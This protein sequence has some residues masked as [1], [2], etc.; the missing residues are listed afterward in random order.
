[1]NLCLLRTLASLVST[2]SI[3]FALLLWPVGASARELMLLVPPNQDQAT[4]E[5]IEV[6]T[7]ASQIREAG[8]T[9]RLVRSDEIALPGRAAELV[10]RGIVPLALIRAAQIP[11]YQTDTKDLMFTSLLSHPLIVKD[12]RQQFFV[13]DSV[14]GDVVKQELGRK[15]FVVLGF[16]NTPSSS[17][18]F[19]KPVRSYADLKGLK[20]RAPDMQSHEV[21]QAF[22]ASPTMLA[23]GEIYAAL[24]RGTVDG[25]EAR[26]ERGSP[27]L[28]AV[29]GGSLV[30]SFMHGQ[31]FLVAHEASWIG[32]RQRERAAIQAAAA[33]A[34]ARARDAVLRADADL[35][36]LAL[37]S[38]LTYASFASMEGEQ[39]TVRSTWLKRVG[40][41]GTSALSFLD[42]VIRQKAPPTATPSSGPRSSAPAPIYFATN[43]NDEGDSNLSYRFGIERS[44]TLRC[45]E[46]RYTP[47][48]TRAFGI[49]HKGE[50]SVAAQSTV[51]GAESCARLVGAAARASGGALIVFIHGFNNSF[52]FAVRRAIGLAQDFGLTTPVLVFSWPSFGEVSGYVYDIHS[53]TFSRPFGKDLTEALLSDPYLRS[54]S[55]LAHSMGSQLA[56]QMLEF[57]GPVGKP[58]DSVVFVAPDVPRANFIQGVQLYGTSARLATLYANENDRALL[59]SQTINKQTPAGLGGPS[60]LTTSGVE[61]VDVSEVDKQWLEMNH[62]HGFDVPKV[63][64]D[65]SLVLRQHANAATRSLPSAVHDG[66]PY[67][68]IEP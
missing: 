64:S 65:V 19:R 57:A 3:A 20:V 26:V 16:W 33:E 13:E 8:L 25:S 51:S 47:D 24:E 37:T 52:D 50:I 54:I 31:G 4:R 56:I 23:L 17:L 44:S 39:P 5:F 6:L 42:R 32:F 10:L 61:T 53:V 27:Y 35:A 66:L 1:M 14:V 29:K 12:S 40:D 58:I 68:L 67:W 9:F 22:G 36:E 2:L 59:L 15:G 46:V 48:M 21:L 49:A 41:D 7:S 28:S 38:E 11:G 30:S 55:L 45:G 62:S 18:V 43:R 60:R 34:K 63:A